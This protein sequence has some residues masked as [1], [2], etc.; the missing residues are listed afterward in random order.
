MKGMRLFVLTVVL[1]VFSL[2]IYGTAEAFP[3]FFNNNCV[4]CHTDD[5]G[6]QYCAACHA[7]GTHSNSS[8]SD[9]NIK[10]TTDK[11]VYLPGETMSI[12]VSGGYRPGWV[13]VILYDNNGN[14]VAR[15]SGPCNNPSA[16]DHGCGSGD[17]YLGPLT[18]NAT[19]PSTPGTY[20][21]TAAWYGNQFDAGG[22]FFGPGWTPDPNNPN[23]GEERVQTNTFTVEAAG[24]TDNDNDTFSPDGGSCGPV[25]C[26]DSDPAIH[27]GATEICTDGI[28]NDCDGLIDS[29]DPDAVNCSSPCT[30]SD[31]DGFYLEGGSCGPQ[32][33]DDSNPA[34]NPSAVEDCTDGIDN[35][36]DGLIDG[37]DP[38]A[39]NCQSG[40]TDSDNDGFS[41]DGG[42][43][44]LIDCDDSN[45]NVF[46]GA[47]ED[48]SDGIDNDCDGL[49]DVTDD[50]CQVAEN[51]YDIVKFKCSEKI[52]I[53]TDTN[54][55]KHD[56]EGEDEGENENGG[57]EA[58]LKV[59]IQNQG[60]THPGT[61]LTVVGT[62]NGNTIY[63]TPE[64]GMRVLDT[65]EEG[66]K[67]I[68]FEVTITEPGDILWT[69]TLQDGDPDTDEA[70]C[71]TTVTTKDQKD[72]K[73][74]DDDDEDEGEDESHES[75]KH[76][77]KVKEDHHKDKKEKDKKEEDD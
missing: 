38:D 49:V 5:A 77:G 66:R 76:D 30:D 63:V 45:P 21:Y 39:Q 55:G 31:A 23:H 16:P 13:R 59:S 2:F 25:D 1:V 40:C 62:Q 20:T 72:G 47:V 11:N 70:Q 44:G 53:K 56:E 17:S 65:P 54:N 4:A 69:A 3:S 26:N 29:A 32:D 9:I 60:I 14:E 50:S 36:C 75:N 74:K 7:H 64:G 6:N 24:C 52:K 33:C 22:A 28:D 48:C 57:K 51:D 43:C 12:S 67:T 37:A 35:D 68:E 10:A 8:K 19:A 41:P 42:N 61:T 71:V 18:L 58:K 15:S 73:D 46:P 27:P 34:I